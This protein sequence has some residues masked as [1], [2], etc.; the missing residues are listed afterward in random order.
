MCKTCHNAN[1]ATYRRE[2]REELNVKQRRW[3]DLAPG[4]SRRASLRYMSR[5][6]EKRNEWRE[7]TPG[8]GKAHD[9]VAKALKRGELIRPNTCEECGRIKRVQAAHYNYLEPLRVRWL[10]RSCHALWDRAE[11]KSRF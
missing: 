8:M 2:H 5:N 11:P 4:S 1:S 10:C 9:A 3:R 7:K 6:P